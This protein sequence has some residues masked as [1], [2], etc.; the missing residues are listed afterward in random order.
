MYR[1]TTGGRFLFVNPALVAMLGYD[2]A[3]ELLAVDIGTALYVDPAERIP[4]VERYT[5]AGVVDGVEVRWRRK[6]GAI[7]TVRLYGHAVDDEP[8]AAAGFDVTVIDVTAQRAAEAE[9]RARRVE[10]TR[11]LAK[12]RSLIAQLPALVWT[13]GADFTITSVEGTAFSLAEVPSLLGRH[14]RELYGGDYYHP[15]VAHHQRALAGEPQHYELQWEDKDFLV[16][17]APMR[18]DDGAIAGVIGTA[19]DI[20]VLRRV[21]RNLQHTQR[22]ES[23]GVLAGGMAHDFNNLLVAMLGNAE[24]ALGGGGL[25]PTTRRAIESIRTA[26]LRASELTAALLAYSG[27]G[28]LEVDEVVV[29][30]LVEEMVGL[31]ASGRKREVVV[32]LD[33]PLPAVRA[34]AGQLRQVIMNLVANAIDAVQGGGE[35]R[36]SAD[37]VEVGGEVDPDDV[38]SPPPGRFVAI[39]VRDGGCGMSAATRRKIFDPFFTTKPT[40]HGLGLAAVLGIVRGHRGGLRL[41]TAPGEGATF[42]VLLPVTEDA[43]RVEPRPVPAPERA[44]KTVMV[45]DDEETVRDVLCQMIEDLG[46]RAVGAACGDDAFALADG[47]APLH[48]AIVD[49]SMPRLEG[50]AVIDGLRA[51]RPTMPVILTS[52]YDRDRLGAITAAGFLRKPFRFEA[53]EQVLDDVLRAF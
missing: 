11:A 20:T 39:E 25:D 9:S 4:L 10:A 48:A 13:V 34:D 15:A 6:D 23:L 27:R 43:A 33:R 38:I 30:P 35:V 12:L 14:I 40:G 26:A 52:G 19:V 22:I 18:D 24:L 21:E 1:S 47:S 44:G 42:R 36:V 41:R 7:L 17:L 2:S 28:D 53:L 16:S 29:A 37:V 46:Y 8:G 31:V 49:L 3:E 5:T 32:E 45:V 50:R 51:R